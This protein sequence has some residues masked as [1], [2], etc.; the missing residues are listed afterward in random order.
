MDEREYKIKEKFRTRNMEIAENLKLTD[1]ERKR[2]REESELAYEAEKK[3]YAR[4]KAKQLENVK[5]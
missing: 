4:I 1:T 3:A 5:Q 2:L